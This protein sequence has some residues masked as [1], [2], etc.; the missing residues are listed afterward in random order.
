MKVTASM[1]SISSTDAGEW[2]LPPAGRIEYLPDWIQASE[3]DRLYQ[4]LERSL[5]WQQRP[6]KLFGREVL[7]P[8]LTAFH[9]E[10][11]ISYAYSGKRLSATGWPEPL[12]GLVR[13]LNER[14]GGGFNSVLCNL[15]RNGQD[16][17]GWH[18][19]DEAE[20]GPDPLIASISLGGRRRFRLKARSGA[21][22]YQFE[23]AHGSL[24]LMAGDLQ[25]HWL[26]EVPKTRQAVA[27][28]INLT[29][30]RI[31]A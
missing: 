18:A 6:I 21:G 9:G 11:G 24:L 31:L 19:D 1:I 28:R 10:P 7:Q 17:M 8:R 5:D 14:L 16:S 3:A 25:H 15:Y 27:P 23:P 22:R 13:R 26:H 12:L 29:F 2:W 4:V 30:R 20:L